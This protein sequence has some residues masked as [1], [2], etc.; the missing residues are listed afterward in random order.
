M[1]IIIIHY[2]IIDIVSVLIIFLAISYN[3]FVTQHEIIGLVCTKYT[4][5]Y[6]STYVRFFVSTKLYQFCE[7]YYIIFIVCCTRCKSFIDKVCLD[8]NY[9]LLKSEKVVKFYVHIS[10]I[11]SCRLT[12]IVFINIAIF[13]NYQVIAYVIAIRKN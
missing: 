6:Y 12:F 9:E 10:P 4:P 1:I 2:S 13:S 3:I 8:T 5:S 7:L 11:F